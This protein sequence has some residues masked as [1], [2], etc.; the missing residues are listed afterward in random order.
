MNRPLPFTTTM[1]YL[2]SLLAAARGDGAAIA[3]LVGELGPERATR[4]LA[5]VRR[6]RSL[7]NAGDIAGLHHLVDQESQS[8]R[9]HL[10]CAGIGCNACCQGEVAIYLDELPAVI[11][12]ME[13]A[14]KPGE[15]G[16]RICIELMQQIREVQ[17][18]AG[19]HVMAYR[20]EHL[21]KEIV[22]RSGIR[23]PA[24][25]NLHGTST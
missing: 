5:R 11:D 7:L 14:A 22:E 3:T 13:K 4:H 24:P 9:P 2:G 23:D 12:R 16:T 21:V 15:E 1:R 25:A 10:A 20:R 6:I 19:V 8:Q 18:V 17:G